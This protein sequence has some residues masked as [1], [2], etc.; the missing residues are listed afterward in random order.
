MKGNYYY[1]TSHVSRVAIVCG[2]EGVVTHPKT[3]M[4]PQK[5]KESILPTTIFD[6]DVHNTW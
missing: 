4:F 1:E 2:E 6:W 3:I 5:R